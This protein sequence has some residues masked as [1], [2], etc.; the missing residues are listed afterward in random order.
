MRILSVDYGGFTG[1][2]IASLGDALVA[3]G[4]QL[5]DT[6]AACV[7]LTEITAGS[8]PCRMGFGRVGKSRRSA[9][10]RSAHP[11]AVR[12]GLVA[13]RHV[14]VCVAQ[15]YGVNCGLNSVIRC[16]R[17]RQHSRGTG[18][19]SLALEVADRPELLPYFLAI[20]ALVPQTIIELAG[21]KPKRRIAA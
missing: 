13:H 5:V 20:I 16:A 7:I 15:R 2:V 21:A 19:S 4:N 8:E 6:W 10:Q 14:S 1:G 17:S 12:D 9:F 3:G 18:Y 11:A